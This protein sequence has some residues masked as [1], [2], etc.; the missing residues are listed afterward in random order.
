M[1]GALAAMAGMVGAG[2]P[3]LSGA[4]VVI[5]ARRLAGLGQVDRQLTQLIRSGA[6]DAVA[7]FALGRFHG[8]VC[9]ASPFRERRPVCGMLGS[10]H[11]LLQ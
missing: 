11:G 4:I 9:A 10:E 2:L 6:F 1:G 8:A 5:E 3:D 7:A